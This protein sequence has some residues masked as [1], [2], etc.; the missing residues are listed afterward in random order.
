LDHGAD[1]ACAGGVSR[2]RSK[3]SKDH[4][5][6][7]TLIHPCIGRRKDQPYIRSWQMEPLAPAVISALTP[8]EIQRVFYNDSLEPIPFDEPTDLVAMNVEAYTAKRAY[9][10]ASEYRKRG[11]PVV[12]GG[13]HA[14]LCAEDVAQYA[15]SVV[16]GE[17]EDVWEKALTDAERGTLQTYYQSRERPVHLHSHPDR[18]IFRDVNYLPLGLV[19]TGRGCHFRCDF[20]SVQSA[21]RHTYACHATEDVLQE[22]KGQ[23]RR[24][25]F[26]VDDNMSADMQRA[27]SLLRA[28]IPLKIRWVGQC[29]VNAACDEEFVQLLAASGCYGILIGFESLNPQNLKTM[30]KGSNLMKGAY[31]TGLANLR[32]HKIRIYATFIFGYDEDDE[33]SF[34]ATLEFAMENRFYLAAFNHLMPFPGTPLYQ[35]MQ[36]DNRLCYE[37]WWL[38]DSYRFNVIPFRPKNLSRERL[39]QGCLDARR[40]FFEFRRV[41]QRGLDPVNRSPL[42]LWPAFFGINRMFHHEVGQRN[43]YPLGDEGWR[44]Q[45]IK[46][47]QAPEALPVLVPSEAHAGADL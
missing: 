45:L 6:K 27:K 24:L 37:K 5:V 36:Q 26:F 41:L 32:R 29:S 34:D 20:C 18:A 47:R 30:N 13:I 28:L 19:E 2:V 1:A 42:Q 23:R 46:V 33:T 4:P 12:M 16:I 3:L 43:M 7:L 22:I 25:Y 44:G 35:R 14:T 10:I 11:V 40:R 21:Y 17:A 38:D 39:Q 8:R 15:D 31:Q 9:Q